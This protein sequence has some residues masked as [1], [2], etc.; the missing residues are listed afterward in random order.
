M[1]FKKTKADFTDKSRFQPKISEHLCHLGNG[2][3]SSC[4]LRNG[5]SLP[6]TLS[7]QVENFQFAQVH[8]HY[9]LKTGSS[10]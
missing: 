2:K 4:F 1:K 5:R 3:I 7:K 9:H 10:A 8:G 6:P